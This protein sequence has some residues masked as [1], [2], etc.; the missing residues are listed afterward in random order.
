MK[1]R[2]CTG[3]AVIRMREHKLALCK[4][5]YVEWFQSYT[6]KT[7]KKFRMLEPSE[8]V[9]V[10]VSGGKD[11][12]ALWDVLDRLG[13]DTVG[14][15]IHLGIEED[16]YS[17]ASHEKC[18]A[19]AESRRKR[20]ITL[21]VAGEVGAS[22]PEMWRLTRRP[23][24]SVCGLT[25]RYYMNKAAE[26]AG[27]TA[28][29]TGHNLDDEVSQLLGN[30]LN[31][32][33]DYLAQ[34]SPHMPARTE[35]LVKKV[36]PFCYF[37]EKQTLLYTL[38]RGIDYVEMDCHYSVGATSLANKA[39]LNE[40]E[41]RAPGSKRRFYDGFLANRDLFDVD[42]TRVTLRRCTQCGMPTVNERC[43]FCNTVNKVRA[44]LDA[45]GR[46]RAVGEATR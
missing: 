17:A 41:H 44:R 29:A 23:I 33:I 31:W 16:G 6:A 25:K 13:Y 19:F 42:R 43:S 27:A 3:K 9:L 4:D 15:Y 32:Q 46:A 28:V 22:V 8:R 37:T 5:H 38:L 12:L 18:R 40:L 10:A 45:G 20:L 36:K 14:F 35:G 26:E 7:I 2:M 34:Q 11:S 24:C 30:V 21:D 1:C 39:L